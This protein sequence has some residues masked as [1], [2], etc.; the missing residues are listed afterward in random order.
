MFNSDKKGKYMIRNKE[1]DNTV[2]N[3]IMPK[4][5]PITHHYGILRTK[6]TPRQ[7]SGKSEGEDLELWSSFP[8]RK[9]KI[10]WDSSRLKKQMAEGN[11]VD[12]Y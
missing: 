11:T 10:E 6:G 7:G 9:D 8:V 12:V 3:I 5:K 4:C 2:E 1:G